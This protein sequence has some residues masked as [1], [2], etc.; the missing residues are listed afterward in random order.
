MAKPAAIPSTAPRKVAASCFSRSSRVTIYQ[1]D[2]IST[3]REL[4]WG[5]CKLTFMVM[6]MREKDSIFIIPVLVTP[7]S[8]LIPVLT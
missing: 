3:L 6:V 8:L 1:K 2:G 7:P 5:G 4:E